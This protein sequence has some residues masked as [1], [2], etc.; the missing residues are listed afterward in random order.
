MAKLKRAKLYTRDDLKAWVFTDYS[1]ARKGVAFPLTTDRHFVGKSKRGLPWE[2]L[3]VYGIMAAAAADP[4]LFPHPVK[5]A[6]VIGNTVYIIIRFP[7]RGNQVVRS[8]RYQHNFT[9]VLR[10]FDTWSKRRFLSRFGDDG[11]VVKLRQPSQDTRGS[12]GERN[13]NPSKEDN[14]RARVLRGAERRAHDAGLIP[15]AIAA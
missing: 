11:C 8:V 13:K 6:Y 7:D 4:E 12:H 5:H 10:K 1:E 2:C 14:S 3:L 15:P 9:R